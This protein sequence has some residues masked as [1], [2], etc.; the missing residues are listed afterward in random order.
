MESFLLSSSLASFCFS[1]EFPA[2][3]RDLQKSEIA[4]LREISVV[5]S[6]PIVKIKRVLFSE[7]G[8]SFWFSGKNS[9]VRY[10]AL[11]G[12]KEPASCLHAARSS[13]SSS[14]ACQILC[15]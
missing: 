2:C 9:S 10:R 11:P 15:Q 8:F 6:I 13:V 14:A 7:E 12:P 1:S 4:S 3:Q 5:F